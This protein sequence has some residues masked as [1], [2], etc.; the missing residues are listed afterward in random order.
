VVQCN[1]L[2]RAPS[3]GVRDHNCHLGRVFLLISWFPFLGKGFKYG[4]LHFRILP[5]GQIFSTCG[6]DVSHPQPQ[7]LFWILCFL[8][9]WFWL[10]K[11]CWQS[12]WSTGGTL[13][14][15]GPGRLKQSPLY[16]CSQI[17]SIQREIKVWDWTTCV[18]D[19][20]TARGGHTH[21][22]RGHS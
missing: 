10:I 17:M 7:P 2:V 13:C 1:Q 21:I 16:F 20:N 14:W 5:A 4:L 3:C 22:H 19:V 6:Y 18:V 12:Y 9:V 15:Q 11:G 8:I